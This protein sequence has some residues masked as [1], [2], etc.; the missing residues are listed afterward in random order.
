[1]SAKLTCLSSDQILKLARTHRVIGMTKRTWSFAT[2]RNK[3]FA[4]MS[5]PPRYLFRGQTERHL[6]CSPS[7][8]RHFRSP[9]KF[10]REL[11]W[12]DAAKVI[13]GI[14]R[15]FR[16]FAEL[17][18]HPVF[19]WAK[20]E[21]IELPATE[22]AQHYGIPTAL[23]DLTESI[24]VA[25]FF[26]T[27]RRE[28]CE[29]KPCENGR[30]VLY[31][32]DRD[33]IPSCYAP[34]FQQVAIQPFP[35][36]FRQWAWTC[37]LLM[38][39]CFEQ[40]PKLQA[41]EFEHD[42]VLAAE[43]RKMAE[44]EGVLFPQDALATLAE[45][46]NDSHVLESANVVSAMKHLGPAYPKDRFGPMRRFLANEGYLVQRQSAPILAG[47]ELSTLELKYEIELPEWHRTVARGLQQIVVR[48]GSNTGQPLEFATVAS[49]L[50]DVPWLHSSEIEPPASRP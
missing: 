16:Y 40:Y 48:G 26:A 1:V 11:S 4:L 50:I 20:S 47:E 23:I 8:Y 41:L 17:E 10:L 6:P 29:W 28:G 46:I 3:T 13:A 5:A 2:T 33:A 32:V 14:A 25:L 7:M 37:E 36:P 49:E 43:I 42:L 27:H 18:K 38:G 35:R 34:R 21:L 15:T 39:E 30:G 12:D 45:R 19:K 31:R 24:E 22:L 44:C 9:T